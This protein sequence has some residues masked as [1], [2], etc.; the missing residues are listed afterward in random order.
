MG[1]GSAYSLFNT[2]ADALIEA[3]ATDEIKEKTL[4]TVI[5]RLQ[6]EDWDTELDSLQPYLDDPAI[7]RAFAANDI[8]WPEG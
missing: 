7:V 8:T 1:W 3:N 4:T 5:A 6:A 2:V